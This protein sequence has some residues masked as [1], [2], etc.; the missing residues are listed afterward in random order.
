MN[1]IKKVVNSPLFQAA[2]AGIIGA[3]LIIQGHPLYGGIAIGVGL[4]KFIAA[5]KP[6]S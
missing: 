2:T 6:I 4:T 5:F 1:K 3:L